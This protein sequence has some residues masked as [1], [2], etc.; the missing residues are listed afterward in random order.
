MAADSIRDNVER[1]FRYYDDELRQQVMD[2][3]FIREHL[4]K[5]LQEKEFEVYY[6]PVIRSL[7]GELAGYEALVRWHS[8]ELGFL[9]PFRFIPIWSR[10]TRL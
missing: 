3:R 2:H 1:H 9:P 4:D 10:A 7:T 8:K 6:Q 5:A